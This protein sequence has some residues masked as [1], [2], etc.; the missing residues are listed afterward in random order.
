VS[1][2]FS[3]ERSKARKCLAAADFQL[4]LHVRF[5]SVCFV[6]AVF[7]LKL[8]AQGAFVACIDKEINRSLINSK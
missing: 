4:Y 1:N 5:D 8:L 3:S 2:A 7:D 6:N